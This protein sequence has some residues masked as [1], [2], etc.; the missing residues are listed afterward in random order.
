M[1]VQ[2]LTGLEFNH[3][4]SV[5]GKDVVLLNPRLPQDAF[6]FLKNLAVEYV[7]QNP[8][9]EKSSRI[10]LAS[11][12]STST[13]FQDLKL[14][15]FSESKFLQNAVNVTQ[16]L[17][18]K[19]CDT[20][21]QCLPLFHVGGL[22]ILARQHVSG[23]QVVSCEWNI[24]TLQDILQKSKVNYMS[25][26]PTQVF[27]LV[28]RQIQAPE[29]FKY[30]IVGGGSLSESLF[31]EIQNLGWKVLISYGMTET[32]SMVSLSEGPFLKALGDIQ[33]SVDESSRLGLR[34]NCLADGILT[35]K[36]FQ[37]LVTTD[38]L[39]DR[40][41]DL[42]TDQWFWTEDI[43]EKNHEGLLQLRGR[44]QDFVKIG[45]EGVHLNSLRE[46]WSSLLQKNGLDLQQSVLMSLPEPR[47]GVE[48][49]AISSHQ[50]R[51]YEN[52]LRAVQEQFQ[53]Q[54]LPNQKIRRLL[55]VDEIP[56][57]RLGKVLWG[58]LA[59]KIV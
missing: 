20:W 14:I 45:G 8:A 9:H 21:L 34:G 35:Q 37:S 39:A 42:L 41:A 55:W 53:N 26:V 30:L 24:N 56:R 15:V 18:L 52:L 29:N 33:F 51:S 3:W 13:H 23:C 38:L 31:Q 50:Q 48:I 27:D 36:G 59:S 2:V 25:V 19:A 47:L 7:R 44:L 28:Q 57:T 58:E 40:L 17:N 22:G 32:G 12:G 16:R 4:S 6:D 46:I 5:S 49:V 11:S 10:F 54:V 1:A 43:V